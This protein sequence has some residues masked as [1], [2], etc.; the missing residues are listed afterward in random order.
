M[1][2]VY[3]A[4]KAACQQPLPAYLIGKF[5]DQP[6]RAPGAGVARRRRAWPSLVDA[7]VVPQP[8]R[9]MQA[10]RIVM[11]PVHYAALAA[12]FVLAMECHL[13]AGVQREQGG[14]RSMLCAINR[15]RPEASARM[16]R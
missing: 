13:I 15:V 3:S 4:G 11:G 6:A 16:K 5:S 10:L 8:A 2:T 14:A 12:P 9:R 1:H 7:I